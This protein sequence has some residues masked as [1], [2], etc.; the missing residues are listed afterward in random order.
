MDFAVPPFV[1]KLYNSANNIDVNALFATTNLL[2]Q[3]AQVHRNR[4]LAVVTAGQLLNLINTKSTNGGGV[5]ALN[6]MMVDY[7]TNNIPSGGQFSGKGDIVIVYRLM[8]HRIRLR[9]VG[10]M[11]WSVTVGFNT[12]LLPA[13]NSANIAPYVTLADIFAQRIRL[14]LA[15]INPSRK[16]FIMIDDYKAAF[17]PGNQRD[18][19]VGLL[20]D[21]ARRYSNDNNYPSLKSTWNN[22]LED[23]PVSVA[24]E[25]YKGYKNGDTKMWVTTVTF[26]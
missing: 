7:G 25:K 16:E 17:P 5:P 19:K 2:S 1:W 24:N 13:V 20:I 6:W 18:S 15:S 9:H 14:S 12:D 8:L 22:V 21:E 10:R 11:Q 4:D 26:T 3:T 23:I